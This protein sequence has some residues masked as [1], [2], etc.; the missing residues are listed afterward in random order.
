ML[1]LGKSTVRCWKPRE[2]LKN[3]YL[4][5]DSWWKKYIYVCVCVCVWE[6]ERERERDSQKREQNRKKDLREREIHKMLE[7]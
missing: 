1:R 3:V 4:T 6:R 7:K 5:T 2:G